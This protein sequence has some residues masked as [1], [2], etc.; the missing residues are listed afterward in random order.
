MKRKQ[1]SNK[2]FP[3]VSPLDIAQVKKA[4]KARMSQYRWPLHLIYHYQITEQNYNVFNNNNITLM[5]NSKLHIPPA[6]YHLS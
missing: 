2:I 5:C 6:N 1:T 4:Y 3:R